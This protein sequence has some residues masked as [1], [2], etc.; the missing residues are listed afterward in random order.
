MLTE[1]DRDRIVQAFAF[2]ADTE[3]RCIQ[4]LYSERDRPFYHMK[5][6]LFIDGDKWCALYGEN[7][8]EGLCGFG[9]SPFEAICEFDT[10][11]YKKI[12]KLR[13]GE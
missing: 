2:A 12:D 6:K 13:E 11:Y 10:N 1:S 3:A 7:I 4:N 5:A 8:Q 9:S